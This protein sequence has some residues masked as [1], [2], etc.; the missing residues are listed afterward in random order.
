M[1]QGQQSWHEGHKGSGGAQ[2]SCARSLANDIHARPAWIIKLAQPQ[3][4]EPPHYRTFP[5]TLLSSPLLFNQYSCPQGMSQC[6]EYSAT[7]RSY[8]LLGFPSWLVVGALIATARA[9][10]E[11]GDLCSAKV[12]AAR[13]GWERS[14]GGWLCRIEMCSLCLF[15]V[16]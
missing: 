10:K 6:P 3:C 4:R 14:T 16:K 13:R 5:W 15:S 11:V 7:G 2:L 1:R 9:A 12:G 8:R